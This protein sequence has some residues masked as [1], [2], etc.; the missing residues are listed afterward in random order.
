AGIVST[1]P[2]LVDTAIGSSGAVAALALG[3]A[4][5]TWRSVWSPRRPQLIR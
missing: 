3:A 1:G 4:L 2:G 5:A